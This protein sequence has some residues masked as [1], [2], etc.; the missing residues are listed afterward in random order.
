M[1]LRQMLI[2]SIEMVF[3]IG[4]DQIVDFPQTGN[5]AQDRTNIMVTINQFEMK[6]VLHQVKSGRGLVH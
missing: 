4:V 6:L 1:F 3:S 5:H 2:S